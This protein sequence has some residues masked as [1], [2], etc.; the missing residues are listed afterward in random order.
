MAIMY[1]TE[2]YSGSGERRFAHV[3]Q[4]ELFEL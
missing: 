2:T 4:F 1:R 3:L